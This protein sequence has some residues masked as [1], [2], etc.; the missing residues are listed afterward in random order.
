MV[1]M[2]FEVKVGVPPSLKAVAVDSFEQ[3]AKISFLPVNEVR[4]AEPA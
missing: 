4:M 3:A 1:L 2:S